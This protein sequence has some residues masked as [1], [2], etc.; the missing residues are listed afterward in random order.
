MS[1][2]VSGYAMFAASIISRSVA[3]ANIAYAVLADV[4]V[5]L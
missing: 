5:A 3:E 4:T 2:N 1:Y